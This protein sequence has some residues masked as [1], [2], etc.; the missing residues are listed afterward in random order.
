MFFD[1]L[2]LPAQINKFVDADMLNSMDEFEETDQTANSIII[3]WQAVYIFQRCLCLFDN[4][5]M[6]L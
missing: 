6:V 5:L 2:Y 4:C 1:C 3:V